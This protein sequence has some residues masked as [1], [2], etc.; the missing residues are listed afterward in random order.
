MHRMPGLIAK[1]I[2]R[3]ED[4]FSKLTEHLED[5]YQTMQNKNYVFI[6][7]GFRNNAQ[8]LTH[9]VYDLENI[10]DEKR[11]SGRTPPGK[12]PLANAFPAIRID[13]VDL[14]EGT[15]PDYGELKD[16]DFPVTPT[17]I[18]VSSCKVFFNY[19]PK[20]EKREEKDKADMKG[21]LDVKEFITRYSDRH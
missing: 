20:N 9:R 10:G 16:A 11:L 18:P 17:E 5:F 15:K 3:K 2:G 12:D 8:R 1:E 7:A 21:M 19:K 4:L 14:I 6:E 13:I